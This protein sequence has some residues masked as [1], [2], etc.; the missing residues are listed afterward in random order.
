MQINAGTPPIPIPV[1][2]TAPD[3]LESRRASVVSQQKV[4]N[5]YTLDEV[6]TFILEITHLK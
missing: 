4:P 2:I 3:D 1:M 6:S 5:F